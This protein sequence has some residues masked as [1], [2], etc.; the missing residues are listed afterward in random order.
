MCDT[1]ILN[2]HNTEGKRNDEQAN[3]NKYLRKPL[4]LQKVHPQ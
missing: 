3:E 1:V 2:V 4:I